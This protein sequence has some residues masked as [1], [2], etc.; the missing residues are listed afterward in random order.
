M[1]LASKGKSGERM[2]ESGKAGWYRGWLN[3]LALGSSAYGPGA[4]PVFFR[5]DAAQ[6]LRQP[7]GKL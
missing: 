5:D 3:A 2:P 7:L 4:M 1:P 6:G